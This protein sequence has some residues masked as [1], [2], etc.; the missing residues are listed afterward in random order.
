M[1]K[2]TFV[3]RLLAATMCS[4]P[5]LA[6]AQPA[7]AI[8][9]PPP[10]SLFYVTTAAPVRLDVLGAEGLVPG[11]VVKDK[12]YS[13]DSITESTQVLADGNRITHKNQARVY[14][15]SQGR[16]RREQTMDSLGV[17][18]GPSGPIT[19]I[20]INDP[21]A[22]TTYFLDPA[23]H[24]AR[25]LQR[26]RIELDRERRDRENGGGGG[27]VATFELAVPPPDDEPSVAAATAGALPLPF[28]P[29]AGALEPG[30]PAGGAVQIRGVA[31]G[32]TAFRPATAV[33]RAFGASESR[34]E[35]LG[36]QVLEGVLAH[37]TRETSTI[38]A[39]ALGNERAIVITSERW[40]SADI[41]AVVSS[42]TSDPR[43]GETSYELVN[44]VRA[45]PAPDL[46]ALPPGYE[47]QADAG[48]SRA[49]ARAFGRGEP[50]PAG[51]RGDRVFV[52]DPSPRPNK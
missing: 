50:P 7:P 51:E 29:P 6:D 22:G 12:P 21:V 43:F 14:R 3:G 4:L 2:P 17:F 33:A 48:L 32:D 13:A 25:N 42:K 37:G 27:G 28:P 40:Y 11:G 46:F 34:T 8:A 45:E 36:E 10:D 39:G 30:A 44:V 47:L 24:T 23:A 1:T 19:T 20:T 38:P 18:Q 15:D 52:V 26:F 31:R 35:D 16:T 5:V 41:D 49:G 9:P